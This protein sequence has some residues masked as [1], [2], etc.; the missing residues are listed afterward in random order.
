MAEQPGEPVPAA[1]KLMEYDSDGEDGA[2]PA[3]IK[4]KI[5]RDV[6][7]LFRSKTIDE[8]AEIEKKT[9]QQAEAMDED[10]RRTIGGSWR[11]FMQTTKDIEDIDANLKEIIGGFAHVRDSLTELPEI[12]RKNN[13]AAEALR[14]PK[15]ETELT[16]ERAVF[17]AGSRVKYLVD[18]PEKIW[19]ALDERE[20]AEAARR[21]DAAQDVMTAAEASAPPH[22]T[23]DEMVKKFPAFKQQRAVMDSMRAQIARAA[24]KALESPKASHKTIASALAAVVAVEGLSSD[25][26][27]ALY[28][29]TRRAWIRATLRRCGDGG[30]VD[31]VGGALARVLAEPAR[32]VAAA[33]SCFLGND[34]V[35]DEPSGP[36][37]T[38][39]LMFAQLDVSRDEDASRVLF[40]DLVDPKREIE[41]WRGRVNSGNRVN[42]SAMSH[43]RVSRA[44]EEWLE[45]VATDVLTATTKKGF[46]DGIR[47]VHELV[48][49]E[50]NAKARAEKKK[51]G[52]NEVACADLLGRVVD[53]WTA[54]AE[55][56]T[57]HRAK[58]L[59]AETLAHGGLRAAVDAALESIEPPHARASHLSPPAEA[60]VAWG[61]GDE[62]ES[63]Q[64]PR[65][66]LDFQKEASGAASDRAPANVARARTLADTFAAALR[67]ARR[68]TLIAGVP[69]GAAK[70]LKN[71]ADVNA[72]DAPRLSSLEPFV[73][74][75]CRGGAVAL[76][77]FLQKRL[78]AYEKDTAAGDDI[79]AERC[80]LLAQ[81]A[82]FARQRAATELAALMGPVSDWN[83]DANILAKRRKRSARMKSSGLSGSRGG[84]GREDPRLA[85]SLE[86]F[87]SV[88][89]RGFRLWAG[90]SARAIRLHLSES[91]PRDERLGSN[92]VPRD[93]ESETGSDG[94][95]SLRL[96]AL[97]SPYALGCLHAV[98]SEAL[99]CGGHLMSRGGIRALTRA[100]AGECGDAYAD[101]VQS[102][103]VT[104]G[105]LSERG[106][107]QCM[108]DLR[109]VME[110]LLGPGCMG[111]R[112]T[113]DEAANGAMRAEKTLASRLDPIDWATYETFL[114]RNERRAF[115]RCSTLL[116][117]LTQLHRVPTGGEKVPPA[118]SS[119]AGK[120]AP[121]P[122][123]AYLPVSSPAGRGGAGVKGDGASVGA[124]DWS[125][126][127]FDRF[128]EPDE[129]RGAGDEG[130]LLGKIGQ[131]LG[132][133]GFR[134]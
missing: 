118:T 57:V 96:P 93:W 110:V 22:L 111:K 43:S 87:A 105:R 106:V 94:V 67:T 108:F 56:P 53:A 70:R 79:A 99:R 123:F 131:G 33:G 109:F 124:V 65:S 59:L 21:Y 68:D 72:K 3:E 8:V 34:G 54:L 85:E 69:G 50:A 127:G 12:I 86:S 18:T 17:A 119:D 126:A 44:C 122:R 63:I 11:E 107:L 48:E 36:S 78:E 27:L 97:P 103:T 66:A 60:S 29:Q 90:R 121:P 115:T 16:P 1:S 20:Y 45:G 55:K 6:D 133:L 95:T 100:V 134:R 35:N 129:T 88:S 58:T 64:S 40:A 75:E 38:A 9:R 116:G 13:E 26:A 82:Q 10:I 4:A 71:G 73:R 47:T 77:D 130:G 2:T 84:D 101:F 31:R 104:D 14:A 41:L 120:S 51:N 81:T 32:A 112:G 39:G 89:T 113:S 92:E 102:A 98:S 117:L 7:E 128:G 114:W 91:L 125:V 132:A 30:G 42:Q 52:E 19:G 62:D 76:A 25:R 74:D 80:L 5:E 15:E 37:G 49:V 23:L 61:G 28:L 24:R 83:A 46:L